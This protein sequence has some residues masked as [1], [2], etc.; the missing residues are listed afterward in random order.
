MEIH[1]I[2]IVA[3]DGSGLGKC[4]GIPYVIRRW[5]GTGGIRLFPILLLYYIV[6]Y[7]SS[8]KQNKPPAARQ[9]LCNVNLDPQ[10]YRRLGRWRVSE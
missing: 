3:A 6:W 1:I 5:G 4:N 2:G 9:G 10:P 8:R 7:P